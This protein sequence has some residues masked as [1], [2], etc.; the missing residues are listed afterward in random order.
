V[1]QSFSSEL[2]TLML[3]EEHSILITKTISRSSLC[4]K[5]QYHSMHL[6]ASKLVVVFVAHELI[7]TWWR[8]QIS[9]RWGGLLLAQGISL[10][11]F[12][13]FLLIASSVLLVLVCDLSFDGIVW[14]RFCDSVSSVGF[15]STQSLEPRVN[16]PSIDGGC[17][18]I[19]RSSWCLASTRCLSA[20]QGT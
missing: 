10:G 1:C 12:S 14:I 20:C 19:L 9:L 18:L 17:T 16:Y 13:R 15:R 6:Y 7:S 3:E 2:K 4:M 8:C 11:P 5:R